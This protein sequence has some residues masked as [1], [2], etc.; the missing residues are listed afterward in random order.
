VAGVKPFPLGLEPQEIGATA[1]PI[2]LGETGGPFNDW[3]SGGGAPA[4]VVGSATQ[5]LPPL[6]GEAFP[7]LGP[8]ASQDL[9][10]APGAHAVQKAV[11]P[12]PAQIMGLISTLH[13]RVPGSL[14]FS[15]QFI[16]HLCR[17]LSRDRGDF[18]PS[19]SPL[20]GVEKLIKSR[21]TKGRAL[22]GPEANHRPGRKDQPQ[23]T[24]GKRTG[25]PD[26]SRSCGQV[27]IISLTLPDF[28]VKLQKF[29]MSD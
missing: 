3:G 4:V 17:P 26:N 1:E 24:P 5:G 19:I 16:N 13:A 14:T 11:G 22:A 20:T 9:T 18:R 23:Q 25:K 29:S 6:N 12:A 21:A 7:S 2:R 27:M 15:K 28:L 10:A 8:A